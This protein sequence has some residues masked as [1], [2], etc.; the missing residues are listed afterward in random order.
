MDSTVAGNT[1]ILARSLIN[2][3]AYGARSADRRKL[4]IVLA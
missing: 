3:I 2:W 4:S 1:M